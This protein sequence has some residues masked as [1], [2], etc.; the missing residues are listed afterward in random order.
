MY[1]IAW[2]EAAVDVIG[3]A[4]CCSISV[5]MAGAIASALNGV[6]QEGIKG[7][8]VIGVATTIHHAC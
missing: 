7:T 6:K 4:Q 3:D 8:K 2:S 1:Q 5:W